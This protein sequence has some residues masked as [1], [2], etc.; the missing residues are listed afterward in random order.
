MIASL[1]LIGAI[2]SA[3]YP[4]QVLSGDQK[5]HFGQTLAEV[6]RLFGKSAVQDPSVVARK[7]LD[8]KIDL[9]TTELSFD[10][11]KLSD[12]TFKR[13]YQYPESMT[14]FRQEW[15]NLSP[16]ENLKLNPGMKKTEFL[17]YLEL[18]EARAR[19]AGAER[20]IGGVLTKSNEYV[21]KITQD[22]W[23][24][25][26]H[27]SYGPHRETGRGGVWSDGCH[28]S[29]ATQRSAELYDVR[30]GTLLYV[31]LFCDEFNTVAR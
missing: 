26:V 20:R 2:L 27:I 31:S 13:N 10:S 29:F 21:I 23:S 25:S 16:V 18:W 3:E 9:P 19:A 1:I 17:K 14:L 22:K 6:E 12:I 5:V 15:R 11:G 8:L 4:S 30:F 24:S 7:G 28:V